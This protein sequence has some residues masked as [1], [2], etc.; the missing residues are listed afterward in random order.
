MS[1]E[2]LDQLAR[3][4]ATWRDNRKNKIQQMPIE[5]VRRALELSKE[6]S[7]SEIERRTKIFKYQYKRIESSRRKMKND[8]TPSVHKFD[9]LTP[10]SLSIELGSG[11]R[12]DCQVSADNFVAVVAALAGSLRRSSNA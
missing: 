8:V 3:D 10:N 5:F 9:L 12:I 6:I 7:Q 2:N 1:N 11:M 4:V